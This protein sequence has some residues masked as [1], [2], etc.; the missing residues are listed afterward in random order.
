MNKGYKVRK[1]REARWNQW[2]LKL[3]LFGD[4]CCYCGDPAD[5]HDHC[6]P[7]VDV[8]GFGAEYFIK[9]GITLVIVKCCRECNNVLHAKPIYTLQGMQRFIERYLDKNYENIL[10]LTRWS[11]ER[12]QSLGY[13]LKENIGFQEAT[14]HW[15]AKRIEWCRMG[16]IEEVLENAIRHHKRFGKYFEKYP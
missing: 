13:N 3:D 2:Y 6:P 15:L 5:A 14:R 7:L 10:T 9:K 16:V 11:D 1:L 8:S 12:I 4:K